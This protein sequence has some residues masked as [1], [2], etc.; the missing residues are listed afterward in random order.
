MKLSSLAPMHLTI[1]PEKHICKLIGVL[2]NS[3]HRPL[4][5]LPTAYCLALPTEGPP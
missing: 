1:D 5:A 4:W 3:I 2:L